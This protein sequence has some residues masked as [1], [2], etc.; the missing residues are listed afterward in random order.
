MDLIAIVALPRKQETN[1]ARNFLSCHEAKE[2]FIYKHFRAFD[3]FKSEEKAASIA[4]KSSNFWTDEGD[5]RCYSQS[6]DCVC[7][8]RLHERRKLK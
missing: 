1:Q 7:G 4:R 6:D 3:C 5:F 2:L 8:K